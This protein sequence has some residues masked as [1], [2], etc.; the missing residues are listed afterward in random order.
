MYLQSRRHSFWQHFFKFGQTFLYE[1]IVGQN[2]TVI[3]LTFWAFGDN[4]PLS[5]IDMVEHI[6][7]QF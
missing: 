7:Q 1:I 5:P 3:F 6:L 2:N 4:T